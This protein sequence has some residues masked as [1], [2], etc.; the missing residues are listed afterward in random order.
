M[1]PSYQEAVKEHPELAEM[2]NNP[3]ILKQ[4]FSPEM[5]QLARAFQG[6]GGVGGAGG[7]G[8]AGNLGGFGGNLGGFGGNLGGFGGFGGNHA[9][10][11]ELTSEQI[12]ERYAAQVTQIQDMG[13]AVDDNVLQVLHRFNG[14]VDRT[15]DFLLS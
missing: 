9:T 14:N 5:L 6:I 3:E 2:V 1:D 15:I 7:A 8:S 10:R 12:R 11:E 4:M 13:F